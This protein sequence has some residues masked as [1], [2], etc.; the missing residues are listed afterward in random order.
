MK[1]YSIAKGTESVVFKIL[2]KTAIG[3]GHIVRW[4]DGQDYVTSKDLAFFD[5]LVDPI[6]LTNWKAGDA[7]RVPPVFV[8]MANNGYSVFVNPDTPDWAI[9]V[10][11]N[12]V[13]V[14]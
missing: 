2:E 5:T 4:S 6:R 10:P 11:Y 13:E 12:Q 7:F 14:V 3:T 9:A 1:L 8:T